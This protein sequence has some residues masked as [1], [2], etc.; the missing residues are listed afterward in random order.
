MKKFGVLF[1][2]LILSL[3]FSQNVFAE[4]SLLCVGGFRDGKTTTTVEL[5]PGEFGSQIY[6]GVLPTMKGAIQFL[7]QKRKTDF[8]F[9]ASIKDS[10]V[11]I[12]IQTVP[13]VPAV[14]SKNIGRDQEVFIDC[15][16]YSMADYCR[17][18]TC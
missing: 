10:S 4:Q 1:F 16:P 13:S 6:S 11:G 2:G 17:I 3:A 7:V 18:H 9:S 12:F 14:Q 15:R 8:V 5:S